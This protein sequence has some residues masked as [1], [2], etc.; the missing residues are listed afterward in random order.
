LASFIIGAECTV[1]EAVHLFK[2]TA[3]KVNEWGAFVLLGLIWG[4]SFLW[5]KIGVED[6]TPFVLV[7]LRI[8]FGLLGL[9]VVMAVQRQSFPRDRSTIMKYVFMGVFNLV[10]PFLLITWGETR[11]DSSMAA[12]LNGAQPLF[13][14]VIV[15]FWLHDEKITLP[16]LAGLIIGFVGVIVLVAQDAIAGSRPGDIL[17]QLAVV[18][19]AISYATAL[20]FSRKYL[21]GTKPVVQS[22]M[23]LV[24][25]AIIMWTLTPVVS[26][27]MVLPSTPLTWLAVIWLG[28]LGLCIAYLLFFYLNNVWGP[29]RASL[30]T[31]VFPVV[32]VALGIIF[33]SEPLTWNMLVGS[34]LVVGGIVAVNRKPRAAVNVAAET[35]GK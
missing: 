1:D 3:M 9:L 34:I 4:S 16:R 28:L 14:I 27:P 32:G 10:L 25:G 30:V 12:I 23:I 11:I 5:I 24:I 6:I 31:Y 22:T 2:E 26:R 21:R 7:T 29:T 20:T 8:S 19:A 35:A 17:G 33:L 15:H 13:V 18:L